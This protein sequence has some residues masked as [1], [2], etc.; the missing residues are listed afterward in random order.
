[1]TTL[2]T[3]SRYLP[4][5]V[6]PV[7]LVATAKAARASASD[8]GI[9]G[10]ALERVVKIEGQDRHR[11]RVK[12]TLEL[13]LWAA[14][15]VTTG[16]WDTAKQ[17][18]FARDAENFLKDI[19]ETSSKIEVVALAW[20]Y[21]SLDLNHHSQGSETDPSVRLPI[22]RGLGLGKWNKIDSAS[23]QAAG[24]TALGLLESLLIVSGEDECEDQGYSLTS[25]VKV[26]F[27][28]EGEKLYVVL[29]SGSHMTH[30]FPVPFAWGRGSDL[31]GLDPWIDRLAVSRMAVALKLG[32]AEE[33]KAWATLYN[34]VQRRRAVFRRSHF[35]YDFLIK[36][37]EYQDICLQAKEGTPLH[38]VWQAIH[39]PDEKDIDGLDYPAL[40]P[41]DGISSADALTWMDAQVEAS[42]ET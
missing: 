8:V 7:T 34:R 2:S 35:W 27:A 42:P 26:D 37:P 41:E 25:P 5:Y 13:A 20:A 9:S 12:A 17:A 39:L 18:Y 33:S 16:T 21:L 24:V 40:L 4:I 23:Y 10:P 31:W 3:V 36:H 38:A 1:M 29:Q 32:N 14:H 28:V 22:F 6:K 30:R 15:S 11:T 19:Y